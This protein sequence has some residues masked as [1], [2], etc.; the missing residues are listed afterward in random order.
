VVITNAR[1][2]KVLVQI[3]SPPADTLAAAEVFNVIKEFAEE[4]K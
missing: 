4:S 2:G 3:A 1:P